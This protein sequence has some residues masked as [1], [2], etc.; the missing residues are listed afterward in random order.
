MRKL[1]KPLNIFA[2]ATLFMK[3][4]VKVKQEVM[5]LKLYCYSTFLGE[6]RWKKPTLT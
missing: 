4:F 6:N 3:N 2:K 1:K 5:D